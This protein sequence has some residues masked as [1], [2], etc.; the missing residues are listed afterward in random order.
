MPIGLQACWLV[1]HMFVFIH[2][3]LNFYNIILLSNFFHTGHYSSYFLR[4]ILSSL[5][6]MQ[7]LP[8]EDFPFRKQ[9]L[10]YFSNCQYCHTIPINDRNITISDLNLWIWLRVVSVEDLGFAVRTTYHPFFWS[11]GFLFLIWYIFA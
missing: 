6:K 7:K 3:G 2:I 5:A 11:T 10:C 8:D 1:C 9:V 4:G